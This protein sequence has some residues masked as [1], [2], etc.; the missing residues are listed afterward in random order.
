MID[1]TT[2]PEESPLID[3]NLKK[4]LGNVFS[5]LT[6]EVTIKAVLDMEEEKS[7][8]QA[9]LL[10]CI[11]DISNFIKLELYT[12]EEAPEE[13]NTDYL[14]ATGLYKAGIYSGAAFHG[15]PGGQ[16]INS[17]VLG[18]YNLGS[19]GQPL[20]W[21]LTRKI[22]KINKKV[23]IK[24]CVSLACHHC[25]KVVVA[26]QRIAFLNENVEAEMIDATLYKDL[27]DRYEIE[28]IPLMIINDEK[29]VVGEKSIEEI[30]EIV[31]NIT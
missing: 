12:K 5:K 7:Q 11:A 8:E 6:E 23:N 13:I 20:G 2:I 10:R 27:I 1:I 16:E 17:F 3:D 31:K 29:K 26:C 9:S 19:A 22:K 25:P 24:I 15:V 14:P 28:R 30:V 21:G 18:I 4:E